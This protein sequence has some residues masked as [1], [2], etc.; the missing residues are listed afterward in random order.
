MGITRYNLPNTKF[1]RQHPLGQYIADF[2][3]HQHK[4]VIEVDGSIHHLPEV[5]LNDLE[6]RHS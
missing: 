6:N 1:T 2:Y 3:C 4:L 5:I